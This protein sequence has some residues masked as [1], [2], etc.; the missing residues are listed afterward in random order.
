[1]IRNSI[2]HGIETPDERR[3]AGKC[4]KGTIYLNAY[5][6]EGNVYI[7]V[8]DDGAGIDVDRV[9]RK[10]VAQGLIK[11]NEE[12]SD[13]KLVSLIFMPGFSTAEKVT[14]LSGRGVGMDVVKNNIAALRGTVDVVNEKGKGTLF[15]IKLPLTMAIIEGMLCSVGSSV[16]IIPLLSIVESIQPKQDAIRTVE[17]QGEVVHVRG[18]YVSLIR[19]YRYYD[20]KPEFENPWEALLIIVESGGTKLA[21]MVD[22]LLGQQQ[23]VIK[24]L[25][26]F[27]TKDRSVSGAAIMGDGTV[28]LIVDIHGLL[29]DIA[30]R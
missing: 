3:A 5:H 18:E 27:I 19:L 4:P 12:L 2:D 15:R 25:D 16:Y 11:S 30:R 14:D 9:R 23:V 20:I 28:A 21:V 13:E 22:D 7:E 1:M 8:S 10:A 26:N 24:S 17:G 6:Q 29:N